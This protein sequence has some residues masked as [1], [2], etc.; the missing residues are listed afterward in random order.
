M[1]LTP[2]SPLRASVSARAVASGL[3]MCAP[4]TPIEALSAACWR[5]RAA[6]HRARVLTLTGGALAA[7]P[8]ETNQQRAAGRRRAEHPVYNF[9]FTYYSFDPNLLLKYSPGL[10]VTLLGVGPTEPHLY[11]GRGWREHLNRGRGAMDARQCKAGVRKAAR[12][13]AE[14]MRLSGS[15]QPHLDCTRGAPHALARV[16]HLAT[17]HP[18]IAYA[19]LPAVD[20]GYGLHEWAMLYAPDA[21]TAQPNKHQKLPLRL[22]QA[23]LNAVVEATP[24]ACTHF[25]AYRFFTPDALP[26]NTVRPL[27]SR[28]TQ[29]AQEQPGCVHASMDL[30]RYAVKLWPY[31]PSELLADA[32]ELAIA[33]RVLDMRASPYDLSAWHAEAPATGA[34]ADGAGGG[35]D[36]TPVRIETAAGRREYQREQVALASRAKPVRRRMLAAYEMAMAVWDHDEE[37]GEE[38]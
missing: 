38:Q 6:A 35:F 3:Q 24:I 9:L 7:D 31:L 2:A 21:T 14:V 26:L 18:E 12:T 28:Q 8:L 5:S 4:A 29:S 25:D 27:P 34:A 30:F 13:A 20:S 1:T 10:G 23:E 17:R 15:R 36:F 37:Q 22:T 19:P 16:H 33:A 11:T 32:L